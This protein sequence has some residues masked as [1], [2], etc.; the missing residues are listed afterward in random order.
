MI[1]TLD[2][3]LI[4]LSFLMKINITSQKT[5]AQR[6]SKCGSFDNP[7]EA[8]RIISC[9]QKNIILNDSYIEILQYALFYEGFVTIMKSLP[10]EMYPST[11]RRIGVIIVYDLI[12]SVEPC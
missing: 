4:M 11:S 2:R 1:F 9:K 12:C 8:L 5:K 3:R 6:Y 10:R 7:F